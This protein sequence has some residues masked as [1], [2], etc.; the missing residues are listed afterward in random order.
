MSLVET[1]K[2]FEYDYVADYKL[3]RKSEIEM[4]IV[5]E[6]VRN[7]NIGTTLRCAV[8]FGAT[9]LIIVGSDKISTHGAHGSQ[10]HLQ[11]LHFFYL[12]E[13]KAFLRS[14]NCLI[15]AI[16]PSSETTS[17]AKVVDVR[18]VPYSAACA[19]VL[20]SKSGLSIDQARI[21]DSFVSVVFPKKEFSREVIYD[22]T[23]S[24][25][26]QHFTALMQY[27]EHNFAGQKFILS[28]TALRHR[29]IQKMS[30]RNIAFESKSSAI[31]Y[32]DNTVSVL[33]D[34]FC[35][36]GEETFLSNFFGGGAEEATV[37]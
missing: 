20:A 37:L 34:T 4:Y 33:L 29:K 23:V 27:R 31:D 18:S 2:I 21:C 30:D 6:T 32:S 12:E 11:I 14:K 24:I 9:A 5:I 8:A 17:F 10:H 36:P 15:H 7:Q 26:L 35:T 28:E 1:S 13:C 25:V 19:F 16:V 22:V 3:T